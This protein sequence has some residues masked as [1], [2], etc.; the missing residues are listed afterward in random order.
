MKFIVVLFVLMISFSISAQET[1]SIKGKLTDKELNNEPMAFANV[2]IKGST[3]GTTSDFDGL[4]EIDNLTPGTYT[5]EFSYLG[6]ET[7]NMPNIVIEEGKATVLNVAMG[8]SKGVSLEEVVVTS[9]IK[10]DSEVALLLDQKKAVAIKES[11]GAQALTKL[12]VSNAASAT[13]KIS[14]VSS[15]E[16]SG[17]VFVRGLGDRYLTTTMNGLPIPSD[18]IEKKNI[19]LDLFPTRIIQNVSISKTFAPETSADQASGNIDITTKQLTGSEEYSLGFGVGINTN[20]IAEG[21]D[22]KATANTGDINL[23]FHSRNQNVFESITKQSWD[24]QNVDNP[25]D[26]SFNFTAGK[27]LSDKLALFVT[28][29]QSN[30]HEYG[31]GVF[32][33]YRSNFVDDT[34]TDARTWEKK[35]ITTGMADLIY[36]VNENHK[37]KATA[38]AVNKLS[39]KIFEGGR[40]MTSSI[41][42]ETEEDEGLF[43]FVRDQN[44]KQTTLL[45]GQ[46]SGTHRLGEEKHKITWGSGYNFLN[47]QEPNRIRNEV[48]F[49]EDLVQLGRTGGFQQRKSTQKIEDNEIN[50]YIKDHFTIKDEEEKKLNVSFG[51]NYR[52]KER[53][54]VSQFIG[55]EEA[56]TNAINPNSIDELSVVFVEKNFAD[57]VLEYNILQP[58]RYKGKLVSM[59]G[60]AN[61][62]LGVAKWNFNVG[63]RYQAD[64]I[65]V[66]YDVGNIPGRIGATNKTYNNIYPSINAK[67]SLTDQHALR[68][69]ASKTITLPEFKEIAP[70][71]YVSPT[72]QVTRGNPDLE[73]SNNYNVDLKWEYFPS[74]GQLVSLATFY[75]LINDPINQVQD[76]GSAGIFSYFNSGDKANVFGLELETKIDLIKPED[77]D[78]PE[79]KLHFNATRMWHSQDLKEL[80]DAEGNF[81]RTFRYKG[82]TKTDLQGASDWIMNTSINFSTRG[83][84]PFIAALAANYASDKIYAL[85]SPEDQSNSETE[86]NDAII[87]KGFVTLDAIFSKKVS[88]HL[89]LR[90]TGKNLLNPSIERTQLVKPSTTNIESDKVVRSYTRGVDLR[91]GVNYKF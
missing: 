47:A 43:Q 55:V 82:L 81:I 42:E 33:Q 30:S 5:V 41:F 64:D 34:I 75:K 76:R 77:N 66:T 44:T 86:Y 2:L 91:I 23:G 84:K 29:S 61:V 7:I 59:A 18:E 89:T 6:Y 38:L 40:D 10:K 13:S 68:F 57:G 67:Y 35:V 1:G 4:Y 74:N 45:I 46:L 58:D 24:T 22:F 60:F 26:Y 20:S 63:F 90:F 49:N 8:A 32:R 78:A 56:F 9:S 65:D 21:G 87:E 71:E 73:A 53:D 14:G 3:K 11:I 52:N 15:N 54:F 19:A 79:L 37:I 12:G 50:A 69:A 36:Y 88:K 31:E 39:D 70:F 27:K 80:K 62:N 25:V 85:G 83:S 51:V 72:G 48:N 17:D 28:G 16:G